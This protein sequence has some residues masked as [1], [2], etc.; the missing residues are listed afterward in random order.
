LLDDKDICERQKGV[1]REFGSSCAD[2]C[3]DQEVFFRL[4]AGSVVYAC[5]CGKSKCWDYNQCIPVKEYQK[6]V[7]KEKKRLEE[8]RLIKEEER[9]LEEGNLEEDIKRQITNKEEYKAAPP[10]NPLSKTE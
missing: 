6:I 5:D 3:Y 9:K 8:E 1:W 10:L 2:N 7:E 4:C